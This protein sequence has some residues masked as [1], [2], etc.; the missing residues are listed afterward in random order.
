VDQ[1][2]PHLRLRGSLIET[3]SAMLVT[4]VLTLLGVGAVRAV[5]LTESQLSMVYDVMSAISTHRCVQLGLL[6]GNNRSCR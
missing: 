5:D 4:A 2:S 3:S 1:F 6:A